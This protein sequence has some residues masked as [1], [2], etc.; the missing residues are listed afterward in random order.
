[1]K[2]N[3]IV[4][5]IGF[6][7]LLPQKDFM[8]LWDPYSSQLVH[9]PADACLQETISVKKN[10]GFDFVSRLCCDEDS[11][12]FSY[13]QGR[14]RAK[15]PDQKATVIQA[16]GY[17]VTELQHAGPCG[18]SEVKILAF[19][20]HNETDTGFF[21]ELP[22]RHLNI[23]EAYF[24]NCRYGYVM[25]YFLHKQDADTVLEALNNRPGVEAA[26]YKECSPAR[27]A[28]LKSRNLS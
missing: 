26:L 22:C 13:M 14:E 27:S 1:M 19:I 2:K 16:G 24:E 17:L 21:R 15:F 4:Q 7:S 25:E 5:F 10:G 12:R 6:R 20:P 8:E 3:D 9:E 18:K 23:F 28:L 11:F